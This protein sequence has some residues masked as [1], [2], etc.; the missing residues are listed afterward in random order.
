MVHVTCPCVAT[1]APR[2]SWAAAPPHSDGRPLSRSAL[3][4]VLIVPGLGGSG[5]EHWQTA[6]AD[7]LPRCSRVVQRDW[8]R[9][10]REL[11]LQGLRQAIEAAGAPVVA[12]AHSLGCALVA[13]AV[14]R[15]PALVAR[16]VRAA[17]LVAPADVDSPAHTPPE[18]RGFA[19]M[20]LAR[21]PFPATV[22]ASS[23]DPYVT[24]ARA[25]AFAAAWGAAFVDA[26]AL[27]HV[28]AASG[29]GDWPAGRRWLRG[30]ARQAVRRSRAPYFAIAALITPGS[31]AMTTMSRS[32]QAR[33]DAVDVPR[34]DGLD[35]GGVLLDLGQ[36]PAHQPVAEDASGDLA[37]PFEIENP[38]SDAR[39]L[40]AAYRV[41]GPVPGADV[42][43]ERAHRFE[44]ASNLVISDR[45]GHPDIGG[46]AHQRLG[47]ALD[48]VTGA[49][50]LAE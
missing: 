25:R 3:A 20:P 7:R 11:W 37:S 45:G 10:D 5:P 42:P 6:W 21:L 49:E 16:A 12:V 31:P 28:N 34:V 29:L 4:V 47:A 24:L 36:G 43:P 15:W 26:G 27:G 39:D 44:G 33:K 9:P 8:D 13:H 18:T 48:A 1:S 46:T 38:F 14:S 40:V 2:S 35:V 23:D 32:A 41:G 50:P 19:P 22:I 17:L 30:A